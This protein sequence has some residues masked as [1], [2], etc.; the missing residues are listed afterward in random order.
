[1]PLPATSDVDATVKTR[2]RPRMSVNAPPSHADGVSSSPS[3]FAINL[4]MSPLCTDPSAMEW[5][6]PAWLGPK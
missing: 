2:G 6:S 1:M 4:I 3:G 5:A